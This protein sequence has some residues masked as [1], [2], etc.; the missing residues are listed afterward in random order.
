M[1]HQKKK[2][3]FYRQFE[4][5]K[6]TLCNFK[7]KHCKKQLEDGAGAVAQAIRCLPCPH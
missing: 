3:R 6:I 2:S 1:Y 4:G 7:I 5:G